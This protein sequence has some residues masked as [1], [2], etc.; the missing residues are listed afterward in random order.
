MSEKTSP[1]MGITG[2]LECQTHD[3]KVVGSNPCGGGGR[4]FFSRVNFL[5]WVL[6]QYPF[7]PCVTVV[8]HKRS[9]SFCQKCR[10]QVTAKH[11]C[12]ICLCFAWSDMVHGCVVYT[13]RTDTAAVSCGTSHFSVFSKIYIYIKLVTHVESHVSAASLLKSGEQCYYIKA[14]N[15][16]KTPTWMASLSRWVRGTHWDFPV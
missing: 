14:I 10:W 15:N 1:G 2:W 5:C 7:H 11:P 6:F 3:W 13:E 9:Q 4:I 8:A 12:T 16:N